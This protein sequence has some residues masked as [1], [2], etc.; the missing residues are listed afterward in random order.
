VFFFFFFSRVT[1][2]HSS[3]T[4]EVEVL[5]YCIQY[6]HYSHRRN[7]SI[8]PRNSI[9]PVKLARRIHLWAISVLPLHMVL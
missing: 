3:S 8:V 5:V 7:K 1:M 2:H 6:I 4:G 9:I